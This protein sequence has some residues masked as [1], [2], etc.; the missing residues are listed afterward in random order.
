MTMNQN[1]INKSNSKYTMITKYTNNSIKIKV[2]NNDNKKNYMIELDEN[3]DSCA[4]TNS[5]NNVTLLL[6]MQICDF[7]KNCLE[8]KLYYDV[9][10]NSNDDEIIDMTF[11]FQYEKFNFNY[12]ISLD[13]YT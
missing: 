4:S 10:I 6:N 1:K 5:D 2:R 13:L 9:C 8:R 3:E 11:T 12:S 7:I